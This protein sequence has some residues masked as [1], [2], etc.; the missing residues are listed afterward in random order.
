MP[1]RR[2]APLKPCSPPPPAGAGVAQEPPSRAELRAESYHAASSAPHRA[3]PSSARGLQTSFDLFTGG[4]ALPPGGAPPRAAT[5]VSPASR[6]NDLRAPDVTCAVGG[7]GGGGGA[8]QQQEEEPRYSVGVD[9]PPAPP[10]P[11]TSRFSSAVSPDNR[12]ADERLRDLRDDPEFD[13][14]AELLRRLEARMVTGG[15]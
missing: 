5:A 2:A 7:G 10:P 15:R 3:A 6:V 1:V 8:S 9:A 14:Q 13:V 12:D 4:P 11:S